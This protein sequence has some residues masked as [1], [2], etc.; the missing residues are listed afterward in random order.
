MALVIA[1][2]WFY[3][4]IAAE[5]PD[6]ARKHGKEYQFLRNLLEDWREG[7]YFYAASNVD[8]TLI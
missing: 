5:S 3:P 1:M 7:M 2:V 6:T 8:S 4:V